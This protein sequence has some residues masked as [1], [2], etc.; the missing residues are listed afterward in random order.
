MKNLLLILIVLASPQ[1]FAQNITEEK[2]KGEVWQKIESENFLFYFKQSQLDD[3]AEL[4]AHAEDSYHYSSGLLG[5]LPTEKLAVFVHENPPKKSMPAINVVLNENNYHEK[6]ELAINIDLVE[7]MMGKKTY[8]KLPEWFTNGAAAF[9]TYSDN[10]IDQGNIKLQDLD[11]LS[12]EAA[13]KSGMQIWQY[14]AQNHGKE[15]IANL[16]NLSRILEDVEAG[17]AQ[18][19]GIS[20]QE[21]KDS[22]TRYYKTQS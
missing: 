18:L 2:I 9:A 1:I 4:L 12:G 21:F 20:Y 15:D 22:L 5:L 8:R 6:M 16:L 7:D 17:I 13:M 10:A 3:A 11:Q 14:I 19:W